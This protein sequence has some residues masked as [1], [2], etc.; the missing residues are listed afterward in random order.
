MPG[1]RDIVR[2]PPLSFLR[3][4]EEGMIP[5]AIA[6][7]STESISLRPSQRCSAV[8]AL[9]MAAA[10]GFGGPG[11]AQD[12][13][14]TKVEALVPDLEAYVENGM[15]EFDLPGLGI[16]IVAGDKLVYARGFGVRR[17]GGEPVDTKTVFQIGSTTK[18]FLATTLAIAVDREKFAW[19]DHVVD[20]YPDFQLKDA[21]VT[22]EFRM[23]DIIAQR[24]GLPPYANDSYGVLGADDDDKIRSLRYV[25]PT[26]SFRST[27]TYT[28]IT[29]IVA[30]RIVAEAM[31][32]PDGRP[33]SRTRSSRRSGWRIRRGRWRRSN[34]RRTAPGVTC[35]RP[36]ARSRS[37][38]IGSCPTTSAG[39]ARSTRQSRIW[40]IGS[41]CS[42]PTGS[43]TASAS[44]RPRT[45]P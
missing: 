34:P 11:V 32:A 30:Q 31:G 45:S 38:L 44:S 3:R 28:N 16:G 18:A 40:R 21:W 22:R 12:S 5:V 41:G 24:S 20:L 19:D 15:R 6:E 7:A 37:P 2:R 25:E 10:V 17:K 35:G 14:E 1:V 29:H 26:S 42:S 39:P 33:S 9:L 23:F 43:L 8:A 4:E 13:M 27:F 36:P